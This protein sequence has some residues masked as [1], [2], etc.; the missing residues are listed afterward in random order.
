MIQKQETES[1]AMRQLAGNTGELP[2]GVKG[3]TGV[4]PSVPIAG[5]PTPEIMNLMAQVVS[6]KNMSLAY[7][8]VVVNKGSA[9]VD[10]MNVEELKSY[11]HT[12]W[13]KIRGKLEKGNYSPQAVRKVEI[14]KPCGGKRMLGIPTVVD[15]MIQ[16]GIHQV[17]S[18]IFEPLFS[19]GSYGF[20][21]GRSA[22]DGVRQAK[23]YQEEGFKTVVDI[24]LAKF[25]D[26]V[27]H[28]R[29]MSRIMERTSGEWQ[30]HRLIHRYLQAG[31]MEGGVVQTRDKGTPSRFPAFP[32]AL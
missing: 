4:D 9:G 20:R 22:S 26:E 28:A 29:L 7:H 8:R 32:F 6:S 18:P 14:P 10:G 2:E 23:I 3:A 5:Q 1:E 27:N 13:D 19:Q 12:H 17:L 31:I 25:F 16:Q 30:L 24:D 11:L 15:R 21:P